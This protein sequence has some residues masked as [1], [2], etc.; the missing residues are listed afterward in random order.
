MAFLCKVRAPRKRPAPAV[1][2]L[3]DHADANRVR[4]LPLLAR[5]LVRRWGLSP[6]T[7][8]NVAELAGFSVE[9]E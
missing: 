7:A 5:R 6:A 4:D 8:R 3:F 9:R 2:P 1:L